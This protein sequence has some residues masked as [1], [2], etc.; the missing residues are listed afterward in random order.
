MTAPCL[1]IEEVP[2]RL[3]ALRAAAGDPSY[4]E[5][6]RRVTAQRASKGMPGA[7]A[8]VSRASVYDCFREGRKRFDSNC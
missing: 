1:R 5:I 3:R 7:G 6:A 2:A 4:A 8:I